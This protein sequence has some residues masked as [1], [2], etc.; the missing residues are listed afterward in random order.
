MSGQPVL[1][2]IPVSHYNEKARWALDYKNVRHERRAPTPPAHMAVSLFLTRGSAKTFPVLQIG[3]RVYGDSTE[4]IAALE[5]LFPVPPLYPDDSEEL[6]RALEIEDFFDEQVAPHVR[7]LAWH[8]ALKDPEALGRFAVQVLP[9]SMRR[10][11]RRTAGPFAAWFL[12]RRYGVGDAESATLARS[13]IEGGL[14]ML[15]AE[16]ADGREYLVGERFSVADLT[17]A[18]ILYPMVRP[19][20]G[21]QGLPEVPEGFQRF[22]D[23]FAGRRS[24]EW[25]GEMFRRHR[26]RSTT[27]EA[28][29]TPS[30][31]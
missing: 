21:P 14:E 27:Q 28:A 9:P 17:A 18:A 12:K 25:V 6:A 2:H 23:R 11:S 20:E 8:E 10:V 16:L 5:R 19:P 7:L 26:K 31:A 15:D 22:V 4:I 29:A 1:W 30:A 24:L 13:R 3:G